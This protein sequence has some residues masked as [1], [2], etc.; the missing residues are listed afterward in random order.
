MAAVSGVGVYRDGRDGEEGR[1]GEGEGGKGETNG[2][3][4]D[5]VDKLGVG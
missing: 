1:G 4:N 5:Q 2:H 3:K